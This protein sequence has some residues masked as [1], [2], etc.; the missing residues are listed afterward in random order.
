V[1]CDIRN[2]TC[3]QS[4]PEYQQYQ[5]VRD[6]VAE[7]GEELESPPLNMC[8]AA[9]MWCGKTLFS[10]H[11]QLKMIDLPRQARDKHRKSWVEKEASF[12]QGYDLDGQARARLGLPDRFAALRAA[13]KRK[14]SRLNPS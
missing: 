12:L 13:S 2:D 4:Y 9:S 14:P 6:R 10:S 7:R 1:S 8:C 11:F 3:H 5:F